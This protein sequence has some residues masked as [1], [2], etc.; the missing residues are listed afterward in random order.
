MSL[1]LRGAVASIDISRLVCVAS[2]DSLSQKEERTGHG[3]TWSLLELGR[4]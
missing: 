3:G 4:L 2:E 1:S